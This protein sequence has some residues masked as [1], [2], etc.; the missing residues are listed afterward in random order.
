M[1]RDISSNPARVYWGEIQNAVYNH[2]T[3]ADVW[4]A[5]RNA[6]EALGVA[7]HRPSAIDVGQL[8]SLAAHMRSAAD[9]LSNADPSAPI[10]SDMIGTDITAATRGLTN[11]EQQFQTR[12]LIEFDTPTGTET[13]WRTG[14][15]FTGLP[16]SV[17]DLIDAGVELGSISPL[18][19]EAV[20]TGIVGMSLNAV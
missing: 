13:A 9:N 12:Y 3:T 17:S 2:A 6:Q 14:N 15:I 19:G 16:T 8:V 10:T 7:A 11:L 4:G 18:S 5:I 1:P 20:P